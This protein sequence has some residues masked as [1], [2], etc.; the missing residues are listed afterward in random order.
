M[1]QT[2]VAAS[3]PVWCVVDRA[4]IITGA[5]VGSQKAAERFFGKLLAGDRLVAVDGPVRLG[6]HIDAPGTYP[7]Q[8]GE[9]SV[10]AA[11][12]KQP[13][14]C[15]VCG[16][17]LWDDPRPCWNCARVAS[18]LNGPA[19]G[20]PVDTVVR[21]ERAAAESTGTF[22]PADVAALVADVAT[23]EQE[24]E[25]DT[26]RETAW[27]ADVVRRAAALLA[28]QAE[29][30]ETLRSSKDTA[31]HERNCLVA[32][33]SKLWPAHLA[34]HSAEDETWERDWMTIVCIHAPVGQLTWHIHDSE[35][36]LFAH[37]AFGD[38][39]WD[40][41]T[42]EEKYARL[43]ALSLSAAESLRRTL[44]EALALTQRNC[45]G[46]CADGWTV[47]LSGHEMHAIRA[48]L[49]GSA[50]DTGQET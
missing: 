10:P 42:T 9:T 23:L 41:H 12:A 15:K 18:K 14:P 40:G 4:G 30:L 22:A 47:R 8:V 34:H 28:Q 25:G 2:P 24:L 50:G 37:L 33:L 43:A 21:D 17:F 48:A 44:T 49:A 29:H 36:P 32:A 7:P 35:T 5:S 27:G 46:S 6:A 45:G 26:L 11:P 13:N 3:E 39:H 31:Y 16:T 38:S 1:E 20:A 19:S